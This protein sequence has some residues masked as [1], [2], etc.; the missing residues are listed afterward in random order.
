[1]PTIFRQKRKTFVGFK[2]KG[3]D[4]SDRG[5]K[6]LDIHPR[7]N[8]LEQISH[9]TTN[10]PLKKPIQ[11]ITTPTVGHIGHVNTRANSK[12]RSR[13]ERDKMNQTV[14]VQDATMYNTMVS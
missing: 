2:T 11:N 1:M 10:V 4:Y 9:T 12:M 8:P 14:Q 13:T 7:S 3:Y 6:N 5:N